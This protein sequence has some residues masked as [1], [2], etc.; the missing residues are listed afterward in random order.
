MHKSAFLTQFFYMTLGKYFIALILSGG[1]LLFLGLVVFTSVN[2][3]C[4]KAG[5][6]ENTNIE[7][8]YQTR[9]LPG[10]CDSVEYRVGVWPCA[11]IVKMPTSVTPVKKDLWSSLWQ[12]SV[13]GSD[14]VFYFYQAR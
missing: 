9:A 7:Q 6:W 11:G 13:E 2:W 14:G 12:D 4:L 8:H 5:G 10:V 1:S 3:L